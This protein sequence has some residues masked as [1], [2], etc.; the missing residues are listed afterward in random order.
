[1]LKN[2]VITGAWEECEEKC[3]EGEVNGRQSRMWSYGRMIS[4]LP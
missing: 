3:G 1:M 4:N 2:K